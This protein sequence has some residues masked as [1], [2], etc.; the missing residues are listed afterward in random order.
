MNIVYY[1]RKG[2]VV[3]FCY[4]GIVHTYWYYSTREAYRLFKQKIGIARA[5]LERDDAPITY[6]FLY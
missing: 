4:N 1:R 6:G 3:S 2:A 5:R